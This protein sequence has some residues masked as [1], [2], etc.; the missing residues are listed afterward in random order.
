[1]S[2]LQPRLSMFSL[3]GLGSRLSRTGAHAAVMTPFK[4]LRNAGSASLDASVS[5]DLIVQEHRVRASGARVLHLFGEVLSFEGEPVAGAAV[6]IRQCDM[7]G[8]EPCVSVYQTDYR[9]YFVSL[10]SPSNRFHIP[11]FTFRRLSKFYLLAYST[12]FFSRS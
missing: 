1:M 2:L 9:H 7:Q 6:E 12:T 5:W 4:A 8:Q 11:W 3:L 10:F